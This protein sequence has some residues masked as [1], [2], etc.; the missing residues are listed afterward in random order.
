MFEK[1][2][3][4]KKLPDDKREEIRLELAAVSLLIFCKP[5]DCHQEQNYDQAAHFLD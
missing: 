4:D 2:L 1:M 3:T 5:C